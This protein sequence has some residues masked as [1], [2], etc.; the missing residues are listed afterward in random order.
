MWANLNTTE[1]GHR[2]LHAWTI[3]PINVTLYSVYNSIFTIKQTKCEIVSLETATCMCHNKLI[4]FI[5]M[6]LED[7]SKFEIVL[8]KGFV[9]FEYMFNMKLKKTQIHY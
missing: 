6:T 2:L 7:L 1:C 8:E 4:V 5:Q 3:P 9:V